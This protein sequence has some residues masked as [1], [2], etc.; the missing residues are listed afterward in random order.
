MQNQNSKE[1]YAKQVCLFLAELLRTRRITLMR[2]AEIAEQVTQN[3]TL[4]DSEAQFLALIKDLT[5]QFQELLHLGER[6]HLHMDMTKRLLMESQ[7]REFVI[8]FLT[9][10]TGLALNVL[11]EAVK[12]SIQTND[13]CVKFPQFQ[14]FIQTKSWPTL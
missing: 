12:D 5:S 6:V 8:T 7:V 3:I 9:R 1:E 10:D 2:A 4:I 13:L 14:Q 11:Q